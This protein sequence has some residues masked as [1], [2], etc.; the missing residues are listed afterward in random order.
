MAEETQA[1]DQKWIS[2]I[3]AAAPPLS[4]ALILFLGYFVAAAFALSLT[5]QAGY[6]A[7]VWLAGGILL[8]AFLRS[9][10]A[11]WPV[12]L[13]LAVIADLAAS[14]LVGGEPIAALGV[15]VADTAEPLIVAAAMGLYRDRRA[16]NMPW[17]ASGRWMI[18]FALACI[19]AA[20]VAASFGSGWLAILG[21]APFASTWQT[22]V[23]AD[24]VGLMIVAPLL[25]SWTE[26]ALRQTVSSARMWEMM[27]F[28]CLIGG[29]SCFAFT[30][31]LPLLFLAFPVLA[32][33]TLRLGL[34]G[35]TAGAFAIAA[36]AMWF[37]LHGTGPISGVPHFDWLERIQFLQLYL[38]AAVVCALPIAIVLAQ[39]EALAARLRQQGAISNA[40]VEN[41]TQGLC[42]FDATNRL[43]TCNR[44]YAELYGLPEELT[45]AGSLLADFVALQVAAGNCRDGLERCHAAC[46]GEGNSEPGSTELAMH[47]GRLIEIHRTPLEDGGWI[48][49]HEDVTEQ[50][51][52]SRQIAY[53]ASHDELTGLINR[54]A[55]RERLQTPPASGGRSED[56][57]IH[58]IGV[59]RFKEVHDTLGQALGDEL[60]RQVGSRLRKVARDGDVVARLGGDEFAIFQCCMEKREDAGAFAAQVSEMLAQP[61][62]LDGQEIMVSATIGIAL[63]PLDGT[64][65]VEL[66][67]KSELAL[68]RA[69]ADGP[70]GFRFFE[71]GMDAQL[72]TRRVLE[73]EL[74]A[75]IQNGEFELYYQPIL[76]LETNSIG[77][78]EALIRWRHP[79][80]G[81]V[82]PA[83]FIP[84]AEATGLILPMGEWAM[85]QACRE[86]AA[87]PPGPKVAV[88]LSPVQFQKGNLIAMV[89]SALAASELPPARLQLEITESVLLGNTDAVRAALVQLRAL[90]VGISLDDFGTGYSSLSYLSTFP[91]DR[92]KIDRCFVR[93]LCARD[94]SLAIVQATLELANKLGMATTAEGVETAE[95]LAILRA[96]GCTDIQGYY[97]GRPFPGRGVVDMLRRHSLAERPGRGR[98]TG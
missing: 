2:V 56:F 93:D 17:F 29:T 45:T 43:I 60:L 25:F 14:L 66:M 28:S 63:A 12:L 32:L 3:T 15:A 23:V 39:R 95:Q 69:K 18:W 64:G 4:T 21:E 58:S 8:V 27:A 36:P 70:A 54:A 90:G 96:E 1:G 40:A 83:H 37:T 74:R 19:L 72:Q 11:T 41:M 34:P 78:F 48:A 75:A 10:V 16:E 81:L 31:G 65:A 84:A 68:H 57:A 35:A 30:G 22:W 85:R 89:M 20:A 51:R 97:I 47:D 98:A 38:L 73:A 82:E 24:A 44:R 79:T 67:K 42:A 49:T 87:W 9:S 5:A 7:S 71:P 55:F 33:M 13:V 50:R 53:L 52:A 91:F 76:N 26:P 6:I 86:A 59:D 46:S 61:Y 88:N 80:R 77:S 92:I 94:A 62:Q